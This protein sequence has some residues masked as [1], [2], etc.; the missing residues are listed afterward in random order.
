MPDKASKNRYDA[1]AI[2]L[3][4][5]MAT[6]FL[7]MLAS[8]IAMVNFDFVPQSLKFNLYQWH[9]SLGVL[10]IFAFGL[11]I[12]WRLFHKPPTLPETFKKL[13]RIGAH[14]GHWGLYALMIAMPIS[15]WIM[16]SSSVYGLPTIVFGWFE[17]PHITSLSGNESVNMLAKRSHEIMAWVFIALIT[18]HV[19]AVIKHAVVDKENLLKRMFFG[20][21]P[22]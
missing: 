13:D 12:L 20:K 4:W 5:V 6:A 11:R 16:V 22:S 7:L 10:L 14:L 19:L 17:W 1:V 21:D 2:T 15:G 3:H 18:I 9:K 8:G